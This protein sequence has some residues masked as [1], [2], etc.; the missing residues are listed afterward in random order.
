MFWSIQHSSVF[1]LFI[2][3][4]TEYS[5]HF[6]SFLP[7]QKCTLCTV[8]CRLSGT[9]KLQLPVVSSMSA[10]NW[11]RNMRAETQCTMALGHVDR[12]LMRSENGSVFLGTPYQ[13]TNRE[14][15]NKN[16]VVLLH[17]SSIHFP[18]SFIWGI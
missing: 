14:A 13:V 8:N 17:L 12:M 3:Y 5:N 15:L 9:G 10:C 1:V 4:R 11:Q 2:L 16:L 18:S 7:F 6:L